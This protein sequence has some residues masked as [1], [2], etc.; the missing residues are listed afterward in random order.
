MHMYNVISKLNRLH[1][2]PETG[3]K[4]AEVWM[5]TEFNVSLEIKTLLDQINIVFIEASHPTSPCRGGWEIK[6]LCGEIS[7]H[8]CGECDLLWWPTI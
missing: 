1:T 5:I 7:Q 3:M 2:L 4:G 8:S 6:D